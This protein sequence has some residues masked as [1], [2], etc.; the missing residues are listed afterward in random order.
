M[1]LIEHDELAMIGEHETIEMSNIAKSIAP[2]P[3]GAE[4]ESA[5]SHLRKELLKRL[6]DPAS[7]LSPALQV[8]CDAI[9]SKY[10]LDVDERKLFASVC[11][12]ISELNGDE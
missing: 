4:N 8:Y 11:A 6:K 1:S 2:K 3:I 9:N 12:G 7:Q 10:D 5:F